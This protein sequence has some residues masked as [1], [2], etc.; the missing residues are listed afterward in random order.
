MAR[1]PHDFVLRLV[2]RNTAHE[3]KLTEQLTAAPHVATVQ[4]IQVIRSSKMRP[5]VPIDDESG[6][7]PF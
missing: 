3:N 1:G 5:G 2:A 7:E 4:T 6:G